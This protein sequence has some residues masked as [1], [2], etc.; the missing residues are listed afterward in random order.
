M[1]PDGQIHTPTDANRFYNLSH[2]ICYSYGTDNHVERELMKLLCVWSLG[3]AD[4]CSCI[5]TPTASIAAHCRCTQ[6]TRLPVRVRQ[7]LTRVVLSYIQWHTT[8][9]WMG[10]TA[11]NITQLEDSDM[12]TESTDGRGNR[13][14]ANHLTV[15]HSLMTRNKQRI[16]SQVDAQMKHRTLSWRAS[17]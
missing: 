17:Q 7:Q 9:D 4:T 8:R 11:V 16:I 15:M 14:C 2:A 10:V 12:C 13:A 1:P 6:S 5:R 3:V